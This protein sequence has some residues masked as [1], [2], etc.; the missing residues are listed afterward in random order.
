M[1]ED[2]QLPSRDKTVGSCDMCSYPVVLMECE[3][4]E[5]ADADADV[6]ALSWRQIE[7]ARLTIP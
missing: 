7:A 3:C 6:V 5:D 2:P 4:D 1:P